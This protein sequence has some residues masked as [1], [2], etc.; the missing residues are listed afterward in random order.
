MVTNKDIDDYTREDLIEIL[1]SNVDAIIMVDTTKN[2]YRSIVR[3]GFF[4]NYIEDKGD[5]TALIEK[6]WFHLSDSNESIADDYKAFISY[7][8]KYKGKASRRLTVFAEGSNVPHIIQ[9]NVYP[10]KN[11]DK[12]IYCMDELDDNEYVEEHMTTNKVS[13]IQSTYLFSMF[14]DLIKDTTSSISVTE[15]SDDTVYSDIKYSEWRPMIVHAIRPEDQEQFLRLTDPENLKSSLKPGQTTS[16]D[17]KMKNLEGVFI[18]VK[19]TFCRVQTQN[20]EDFRYVFMVQDINESFEDL[21]STLQKYENRALTDSLTGLLNRGSMETEIR[22]SMDVFKKG[23]NLVSLIMLDID[24]F[25]DVNDKYGHSIG[26]K[27]LKSVADILKESVEGKNASVGRWGGEEF[28]IDICGISREYVFVFAEEI[29]KKIEVHRFD[30]VGHLTCSI[31]ISHV[32]V[33]DAFEDVFDRMDKAMYSSK[34]TG[35]NRVTELQKE[36]V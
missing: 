24:H 35:R 26:D 13:A 30:E 23:G 8:G 25:K 5:Y 15:I 16:L 28:V 31:G 21:M 20:E 10:V 32:D 2:Q 3:K 1:D 18:W 12:Y 14:V 36:A 4:S 17:C 22:N 11:T 33:T 9:M 27:T 29:R 6:L 19:L 7:Y 34:E